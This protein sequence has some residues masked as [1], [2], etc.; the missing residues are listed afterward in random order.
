M[1]DRFLEIEVGSKQRTLFGV[2]EPRLEL[3]TFRKPIGQQMKWSLCLGLSRRFLRQRLALMRTLPHQAGALRDALRSLIDK[4]SALAHDRNFQHLKCQSRGLI[5]ADA[6]LVG[7]V[8]VGDLGGGFLN[9]LWDLS[10]LSFISV[11]WT[12]TYLIFLSCTGDWHAWYA[13]A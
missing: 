1:A 13:C 8:L 3:P 11:C 2:P 4:S 5:L 6:V 12:T 9:M 7:Q 10:I